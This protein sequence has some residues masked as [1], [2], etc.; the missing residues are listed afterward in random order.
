MTLALEF[1]TATLTSFR[2]N[3]SLADKAIAQVHDERLHM[4]LDANTN[5]LAVIMRHVAGNLRSRWTDFLTT[6]GEKPWRNRD[7]EFND[8]FEHREQLL[9]DWESGW[10]CLFKTLQSLTDTDLLKTILIRGEPHSVSLAIQRSVAHVCYHI[11]QIVLIA[12]ILAGDHWETIT[13]PRGES[14]AHNQ[15][16]WGQDEY[17][18]RAE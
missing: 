18:Q 8:R 6:D 3:K 4:A 7:E 10:T 16:V 13:I 17:R 12:R 9:A 14:S 1:L 2:A 15:R 11:G 5:S